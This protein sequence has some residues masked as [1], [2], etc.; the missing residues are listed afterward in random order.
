ME[1]I[2]NIEKNVD[3]RSPNFDRNGDNDSQG[4]MMHINKKKLKENS[5]GWGKSLSAY[6]TSKAGCPRVHLKID[7][8]GSEK[9]RELVERFL[10]SQ[11]G[12]STGNHGM[13]SKDIATL[14]DDLV[15]NN[16]KME[17]AVVTFTD[18]C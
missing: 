16:I 12:T 7:L 1:T 17:L 14:V 18:E 3:D 13:V 9:A 5:D 2:R 6:L 8:C 4:N 15:K 10:N 11:D